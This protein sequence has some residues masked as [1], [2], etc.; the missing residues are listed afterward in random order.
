MKDDRLYLSNIK[1]C[2]ERVESYTVDGK[3]VFLQTPIV[4]DAVIR[5]FDR[6]EPWDGDYENL[7]HSPTD[8]VK[9]PG[10]FGLSES[11]HYKRAIRFVART[12]VL[13]YNAIRRSIAL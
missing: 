5:N 9:T 11:P 1:E 6:S 3:E 7:S 10:F 2:I 8:S 13:L 4:Q 12:L